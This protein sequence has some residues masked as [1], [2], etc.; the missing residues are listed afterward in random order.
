MR[1]SVQRSSLASPNDPIAS[2]C[3]SSAEPRA[4]WL[5]PASN[6]SLVALGDA[7]SI[8]GMPFDAAAEPT[9]LWDGFNDART[10]RLEPRLGLPV[11]QWKALT[12]HLA[13]GIRDGSLGVRK[14]VLARAVQLQTN[15][16][17]ETALRYLATSYPT[18]TVFAFAQGNACFVGATPE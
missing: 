3:A 13:S 9:A 14:V 5:K 2:F 16:R 12:T 8:R 18:C 10:S 11:E 17:V 1:E 6:E 4:L 7:R 15:V